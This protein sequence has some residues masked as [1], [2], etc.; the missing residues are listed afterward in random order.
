[1]RIVVKKGDISPRTASVFA[2]PK[3]ESGKEAI[4]DSSREPRGL[5]SVKKERLSVQRRQ[6]FS[7][8]LWLSAERILSTE[9]AFTGFET[10]FTCL[11]S[12]PSRTLK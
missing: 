7:S 1:M 10:T 5:S 8:Y 9:T 4:V 6:V 12:L 11:R 2:R 3:G